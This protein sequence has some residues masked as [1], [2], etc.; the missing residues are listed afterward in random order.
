MK[1]FMIVFLLFIAAIYG[2]ASEND[3][4]FTLNVG[5]FEI[6]MMV[7]RENPGNAG[8]LAGTDPAILSQYIPAAGFTFSTNTFLIKSPGMNIL[9]DTGFGQAVFQKMQALGVTPDQIDVVLLTHLHPDHIGGLQKNGQALFSKAKIYVSAAELE[10]FTKTQV[11]QAAVA[12][13]APYGDRVNSFEPSQ[14]GSALKELIPGIYPIAL[15][16][17]TPGHTGYLVQ[18][19]GAS[20]IIGGDFLHLALVQFPHPE[21][22]S[23]YD[24][25]KATAA[26]SRTAILEY[27]AKNNIPIGGMHIA[28][29]GCG[30]VEKS[31]SGYKFNPF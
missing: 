26:Q 31:G 18:N 13:L 25:D 5:Q 1:K 12:A 2:F 8:I 16:G 29:P 21:I 15:P 17:H 14:L 4:I 23:S 27:A 7:E 19:G 30:T 22:S 11:N 9:V 24:M 3:G 6:S 20:F 28:Y 10:Y